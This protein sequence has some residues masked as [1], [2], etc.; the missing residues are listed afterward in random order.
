MIKEV[1][2]ANSLCATLGLLR[3]C[4]SGTHGPGTGN[5]LGGRRDRGRNHILRNNTRG[6]H[7]IG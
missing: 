2:E 3:S 6:R 4:G 7:S 1:V 5:M